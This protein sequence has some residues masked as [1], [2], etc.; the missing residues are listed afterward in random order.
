[1]SDKQQKDAEAKRHQAARLGGE[2]VVFKVTQPQTVDEDLP[3]EFR[4]PQ[5]EES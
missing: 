1:M 3:E 2:D 5:S 4:A